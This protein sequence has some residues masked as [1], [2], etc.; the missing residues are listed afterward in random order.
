MRKSF[1]CASRWRPVVE[2]FDLD[3]ALASP[4]TSPKLEALDTVRIFGR[5]DLE[6][7]PVIWVSGEV[8]KP[9][10]YSTSGQMHLRDAIYEAGG[11]LPDAELDSAQL[12]RSRPDGSVKI[13]DVT[14]SPRSTPTRLRTS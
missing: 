1:D 5:Y 8:R 12:F 4:S 13:L 2:S 9:G 10:Q 7:A 14:L 11:V 6:S 3:A